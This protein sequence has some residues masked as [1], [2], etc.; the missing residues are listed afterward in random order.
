M[1]VT[2]ATIM[3]RARLDGSNDFAQ[4]IPDPS[5]A[6]MEAVAETLFDPMNQDMYNQFASFLVNRIGYQ[7]IHQHGWENKLR[8][9]LK[10]KLNFGNTVTETALKWVTAHSYDIDAE[11][12]FKTTYPEGLQAF[13]SVNRKVKYPISVSEDQLKYAFTDD[14]GLSSLVAA[15]LQVPFN[16]DEYD[17]YKTMMELFAV[18]DK[19]YSAF[20]HQLSAM[21]T[22]EATSKEFLK[23]LR[24][25]AYQLEYP[26]TIYTPTDIPVFADRSELVLFITP[27][28][29]AATEVDGLAALFNVDRAEVPYRTVVV[30]EFPVPN[31]CAILTTED[32]FQVYD[33]IYKTTSQ[34]DP[35]G[36]KTNYWLHHQQIVAFSPFVPVIFFGTDAATAVPTVAVK[37]TGLTLTGTGESIEPGGTMQLT[38]KLA[39]TVDPETEGIEVKPNAATYEVKLKDG[40][41][42]ARTRVDYDGVLHLQKTGVENGDQVTVTATSVYTNPSGKTAVYTAPALTLNVVVPGAPAPKP[43]TEGGG[44]KS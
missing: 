40:V 18:Y 32:F 12:Q 25:Y 3:A 33:A 5:Q 30:D 38:T 6:G 20:R 27:D 23:A 8:A 26:A 31:V 24:K 41:I 15:I 16:S 10:P 21:P 37:P 9:F 43:P 42:N 13:H 28:A 1:A 14:T 22:D 17:T 4:R 35:E 2:N 19:H 7:Y 29:M 44:N 34:Y 39:G 11:T 36:L